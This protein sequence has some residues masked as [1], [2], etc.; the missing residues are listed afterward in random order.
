MRSTGVL[1]DVL[2]DQIGGA[3]VDLPRWRQAL[4]PELTERLDQWRAVMPDPL[5]HDVLLA[6]LSCYAALQGAINVEMNKQLPPEL[7]GSEDLFVATLSYALD[8]FIPCDAPGA[9]DGTLST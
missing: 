9:P 7:T 2:R 3:G 1:F 8:G 5:P 6:A 4:T